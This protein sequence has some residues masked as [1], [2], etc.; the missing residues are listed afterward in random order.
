MARAQMM[1]WCYSSVGD[2]GGHGDHV[3]TGGRGG[4][5]GGRSGTMGVAARRLSTGA[6]G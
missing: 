3:G 5:A 2:M 4:W 1:S 6:I